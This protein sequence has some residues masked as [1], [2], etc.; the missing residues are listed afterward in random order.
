MPNRVLQLSTCRDTYPGPGQGRML[1]GRC[2]ER[3]V[4]GTNLT[5]QVLG[6]FSTL[7]STHK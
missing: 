4:G 1:H 3:A 2:F 5:R 6:I 7:V